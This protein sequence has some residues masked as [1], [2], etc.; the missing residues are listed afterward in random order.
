[1]H[2]ARSPGD[3][4]TWPRRLPLADI[5]LALLWAAALALIFWPHPWLVAGSGAVLAAYVA[6]VFARIRRQL[7]ILGSTLGITAA[8]LA[9]WLDAWPALWQGLEKAVI[10]A[11]FFGT[12]ALMRATADQRP[13]IARA[14]A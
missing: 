6:T 1:M 4:M 14:R 8:A 13:E 10:F 2:A 9:G 11:A 5:L 3:V 12:L 7:Q